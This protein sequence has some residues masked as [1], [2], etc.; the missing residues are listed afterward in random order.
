[1]KKFEIGFYYT[2]SGFMD[3]DANTLKEAEEKVK[4]I[5]EQEGIDDEAKVDVVDREYDTTG[6]KF[7]FEGE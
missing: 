4:H 3:I 1:M 7:K 6:E 5:L 2:V